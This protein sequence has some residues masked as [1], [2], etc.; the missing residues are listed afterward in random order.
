MWFFENLIFGLVDRVENRLSSSAGQAQPN[1]MLRCGSLVGLLALSA[2]AFA[3][4]VFHA[5]FTKPLDASWKWLRE[6]RSAWRLTNGTLEVRVQPGNMW[7]PA[8]DAKNVLVRP[9]PDLAQGKLEILATVEN[10]PTEQ[11]EQ[12]DLVWYY[13]DSNMVK[14]GLELV[15]GKLSIVMGREEGDRART[16]SINPIDPAESRVQL[17]FIVSTKSIAGHFRKP[18]AAT[19]QSAGECSLPALKDVPPKISLQFYQGPAKTEHWARVLDF[20]INRE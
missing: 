12:V 18:G 17:R 8:N 14:I 20:R 1:R 7:G 10:R 13:S 3:A 15:D 4:E 2:G 11:Y 16:T 19:W 6:D 5:D 9:A